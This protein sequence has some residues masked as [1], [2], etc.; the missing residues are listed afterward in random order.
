MRD[1]I[2]FLQLASTGMTQSEI[3]D[4]HQYEFSR[5]RQ[6]GKDVTIQIVGEHDPEDFI[7]VCKGHSIILCGG[8]PPLSSDVV[9]QLEDAQVFIRYG[10]GINT[11][12]LSACTH[13]GKLVYYMPGYCGPELALHAVALILGLL[14]N[15]GYYDRKMRDGSFPKASGPLPRRLQNLTV[16][17]F[18]LGGSGKEL[19]HLM[20]HGFHAHTIAYDPYVDPSDAEHYHVKLVSFENLLSESDVI[21]LHAPLTPETTHIFNAEAFRKMKSNSMIINTARGALIDT[22]ALAEALKAG[23]I[24]FAGIDVF[25]DEPPNPSHPLLHLD[26]VLLTPHSAFYGEES[27]NAQYKLAAQFVELFVQKKLDEKYIA[28]KDVLPIW[29]NRGFQI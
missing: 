5:I 25:E 28:N 24:G 10:I 19:A 11:I 9:A 18:G 23:E 7:A 6:L 21:S 27:T 20:T 14:R 15:I 8:N 4:Q 17:L 13:Y 22:Y 29:K 3:E 1:S 26:N 2:L 12:D 16:G